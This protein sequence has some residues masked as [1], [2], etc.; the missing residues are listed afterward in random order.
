VEDGPL[1]SVS[2]S[3]LN[4]AHVLIYA[5]LAVAADFV[6][7]A[8][9][10]VANNP[11]TATR[12]IETDGARAPTA[13]PVT[14]NNSVGATHSTAVGQVLATAHAVRAGPATAF[15]VAVDIADR[16]AKA[17]DADL[18]GIA[19]VRSANSFSGRALC[20]CRGLSGKGRGS[21]A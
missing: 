6:G 8:T 18:L 14:A 19:A 13:L 21:Q 9:Y 1:P 16:T 4:R 11:R 10:S 17:L 3:T 15:P 20:R 2:S 7:I 12:A 5:L